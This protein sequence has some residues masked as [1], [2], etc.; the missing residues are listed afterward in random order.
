MPCPTETIVK[1]DSKSVAI[2]A[3]SIVA[4]VTRDRLMLKYHAQYPEYGFAQHKGYPVPEHMRA[5]F[6]HGP[7]PI[8]RI[9]FAPVKHRAD[10]GDRLE[11]IMAARAQRKATNSGEWWH[12]ADT[13]TKAWASKDL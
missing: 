2:A 4:K 6:K 1:G 3:A 9:T 11:S 12:V 7:S 10:V 8:H 5:V 13:N